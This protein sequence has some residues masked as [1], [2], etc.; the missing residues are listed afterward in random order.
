M[1]T[2]AKTK[3]K[4]FWKRYNQGMNGSEYDIYILEQLLLEH[5]RDT[6]YTAIDIVNSEE[7]LCVDDPWN[8]ELNGNPVQLSVVEQEPLISKIHNLKVGEQ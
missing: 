2:S 6:R 3:A 7:L 8:I 1:Q 5:E 4:E